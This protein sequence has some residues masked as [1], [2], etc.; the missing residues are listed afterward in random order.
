M[1]SKVYFSKT[2]TPEKALELFKLLKKDLPGNVAIKVHSG[3][4]GNFNFIKPDFWKPL[5]N[6]VKGTI[7]EC[8]TAYNG[9]R[10]NKEKH[11]KLIEEHGWTKAGKVD[12]LDADGPDDILKIPNGILLKENYVGKNMKNYDSSLVLIHFKGHVSGGYGGALKQLSIGYG[13]AAGKAYQHSAGRSKDCT[14]CWKMKASHKEFKEA[15]ADAAWSVVDFFKGKLA[16]VAVMANISIDCDCNGNPQPPCMPNVG[17]LASTDPVALD[18]ACLDLVYN[19][20]EEGKKKLIERIEEKL[21]PYVLDCAVKLGIG[22]KEYE[23]VN[24]D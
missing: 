18:K 16:Y 24:V 23:L 14:E 11:L 5:I 13:S 6:Y 10:S 3:E 21:G 2:I 9:A 15:M 20:K 22:K 7:V 12:I 4:K 19:S 8:N 1:A 17:I